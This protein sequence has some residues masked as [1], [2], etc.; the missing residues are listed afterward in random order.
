MR[1]KKIVITGAESTGKSTLTKQL[2][3]HYNTNYLKEYSREYVENLKRKYTYDDV[4]IITRKQIELEEQIA[5]NSKKIFF[6]DTS[7]IVLKV[8]F[9]VVYNKIPDWF[10]K[11]NRET[12]ADFYLLCNNDLDWIPDKVRENNGQM[13]DFLHEKYKENLENY[14]LNYSIIS[15]KNNERIQKSVIEID[16]FLKNNQL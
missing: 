12:F 11:K 2:A 13:R 14:K 4:V 10:E 15:G 5:N 16:N 6:V 3:K 7:L 9:E 8:W 1:A